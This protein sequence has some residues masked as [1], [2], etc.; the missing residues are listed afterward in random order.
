M[1]FVFKPAL[2]RPE[3]TWTLSGTR[4]IG[5]KGEFNLK[6]T[7]SCNFN[8]TILKRGMTSSELKLTSPDSTLSLDCV[9][10]VRTRDRDVFLGLV[11][12]T[13]SAIESENPELKVTST[14]ADV[15]AWGFAS[16][17]TLSALWG[18]YFAASNFSD[19]GNFAL[20]VGGVM[21]VLGAFMI[22]V[23][24]PWKSNKPK[25]LLEAREWIERL[26]AL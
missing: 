14:G 5:P 18:I 13:L 9:G 11:S 4:L 15:L 17:G 24:S 19:T 22:W 3:E 10:Q 12:A 7:T 6:N 25:S 8:Y 26:R 20:G 16:I 21:V 2:I 1:T 23:G